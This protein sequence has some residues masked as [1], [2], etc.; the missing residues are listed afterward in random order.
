[1]IISLIAAVTE[2]SII[3]KDGDMPWHLPE[4]LKYFKATTTGHTVIMG[5][6]TWES[7]GKYAPLPNRRNIVL[8]HNTDWQASGAE[9]FHDLKAAI[10]ACNGEDEVFI[11]G[12]GR[13][14]A[15][16]IHLAKRLYI[17]RIHAKIDGDTQFPDL[18]PGFARTK[19]VDGETTEPKLTFEVWEKF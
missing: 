18:P 9:V 2:N 8:T 15:D 13:V 19:A 6:K 7:L 12:G 17:T 11:I 3:G 5:R 16:A 14:Y 1:M 10:N 4:D